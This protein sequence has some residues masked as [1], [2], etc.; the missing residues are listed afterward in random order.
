MSVAYVDTS[1]LVAVAFDES[2]G[3]D[4]AN[5]LMEITHLLSSNL[6]E[7][8][9]RSTCARE[10]VSLSSHLFSNRNYSPLPVVCIS[11]Q[12]QRLPLPSVDRWGQSKITT[13]PA[14]ANVIG[15]FTL[16]PAFSGNCRTRGE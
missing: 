3:M 5:R 15:D 13:S 12:A 10:G 1:A 9:L 14:V 2:G 6:L 16:T 11:L 7:A 8:E 4:M